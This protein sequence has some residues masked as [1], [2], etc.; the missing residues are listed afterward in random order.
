MYSCEPIQCEQP[1]LEADIKTLKTERSRCWVRHIQILETAIAEYTADSSSNA[2]ASAGSET[3]TDA[4][5]VVVVD[6]AENVEEPPVPSHQEDAVVSSDSGRHE[7]Y[8]K[9]MIVTFICKFAQPL[10]F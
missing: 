1:E 10:L 7:Q 9:L 5:V 2:S 8:G 3:A 6:S 4:A